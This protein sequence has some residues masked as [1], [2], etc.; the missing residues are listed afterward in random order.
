MA[1]IVLTRVE[2]HP[3]PT[4]LVWSLGRVIRLSRDLAGGWLV[5]W[6]GHGPC[7]PDLRAAIGAAV[8]AEEWMAPPEGGPLWYRT[9]RRRSIAEAAST[10]RRLVRR[11][12]GVE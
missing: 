9:L 2:V 1:D 11:K 7:Y 12:F 3:G 4:V 5:G 8:A 10:A 6:P